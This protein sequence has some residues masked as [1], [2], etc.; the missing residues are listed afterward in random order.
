M[1]LQVCKNT[2]KEEILL[3]LKAY[4]TNNKSLYSI[5]IGDD[6]IYLLS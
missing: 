3:V 4:S 5:D 2:C 1:I 6:A